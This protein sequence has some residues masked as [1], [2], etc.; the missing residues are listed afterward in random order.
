MRGKREDARRP[1]RVRRLQSLPAEQV[2]AI[3]TADLVQHDELDAAVG[4]G[5]ELLDLEEMEA[6]LGERSE[7]EDREREEHAGQQVHGVSRKCVMPG[8]NIGARGPIPA[9]LPYVLA[10][11][12]LSINE[13]DDG[14]WI[15]SFVNG[16]RRP[17]GT[18]AG[19]SVRPDVRSPRECPRTSGCWLDRGATELPRVDVRAQ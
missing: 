17:P 10:G 1:L 4:V 15:A 13:D 16:G 7:R 18:S 12:P 5:V 6:R 3:G 19:Q 2:F 14:I 8:E 9:D 11:Q